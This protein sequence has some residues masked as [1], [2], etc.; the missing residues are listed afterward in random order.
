VTKFPTSPHRRSGGPYHR[1]QEAVD[2]IEN[3]CQTLAAQGIPAE[4]TD[5]LRQL[6]QFFTGHF[7]A[8]ERLRSRTVQLTERWERP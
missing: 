4:L 5:E 7:V 3:H 2:R 6:A 1:L 8:L